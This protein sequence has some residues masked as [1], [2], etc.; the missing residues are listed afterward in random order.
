MPPPPLR[1]RLVLWVFLPRK[2]VKISPRLLVTGYETNLPLPA[3]TH[4]GARVV[5]PRRI[6]ENTLTDELFLQ[7]Y[8]RASV[9]RSSSPSRTVKPPSPSFLP[10]PRWSSVL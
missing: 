9:S 3:Y 5:G 4:V 7:T 2:L 6:L 10:P 8:R 1:P